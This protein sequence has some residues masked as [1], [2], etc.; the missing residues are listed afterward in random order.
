MGRRRIVEAGARR[1]KNHRITI[2]CSECGCKIKIYPQ[3]VWR[4]L[5]GH[6][7]CRA[8]QATKDAFLVKQV[9]KR[10]G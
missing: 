2:R 1:E 3:E 9:E 6:N 7:R 5:C 8:P 10:L 4:R